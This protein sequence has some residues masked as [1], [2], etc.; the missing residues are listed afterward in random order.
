MLVVLL[1]E[2]VCA[3]LLDYS[4]PPTLP[5]PFRAAPHPS[6]PPPPPSFPRLPPPLPTRPPCLFPIRLPLL[7]LPPSGESSV[8]IVLLSSNALLWSGTASIN[9]S[10]TA[11][12]AVHTKG[13][14][15]TSM[16]SQH[17]RLPSAVTCTAFHSTLNLLAVMGPGEDD[18]GVT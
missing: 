13:Y 5:S 1:F 16:Q 8:R 15:H 18:V 9:T 7:A 10:A 12:S 6:P 4:V 14:F 3:H 2:E 17:G 11:S